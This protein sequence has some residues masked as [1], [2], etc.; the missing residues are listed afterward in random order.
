M[1]DH[2]LLRVNV[3]STIFGQQS[4]DVSRSRV[5]VGERAPG[6]VINQGIPKTQGVAHRPVKIGGDR[7]TRGVEDSLDRAPPGRE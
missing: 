4:E 2:E 1:D 5:T 6:P 7:K 3:R